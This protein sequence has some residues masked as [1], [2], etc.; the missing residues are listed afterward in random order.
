M[1]K[2]RGT[3]LLPKPLD[4][5]DT[6]YFFLRFGFGFGGSTP[7]WLP[8]VE[9][10]AVDR[11]EDTASSLQTVLRGRRSQFINRLFGRQ[12]GPERERIAHESDAA[13]APCSDAIFQ[14]NWTKQ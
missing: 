4:Q 6:G 1:C 7:H 11:G 13:F 12:L 3:H 14:R 2:V 5:P 10:F 9:S 8:A